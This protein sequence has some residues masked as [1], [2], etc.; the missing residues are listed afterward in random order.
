M[1]HN[2]TYRHGLSL[3]ITLFVVIHV[4]RTLTSFY[5][6]IMEHYVERGS[7][8]VEC[9]T[10]KRHSPCSTPSL[11]YRFEVCAFP[12]SPRHPSSLSCIDEYLAIDSGGNVNEYSSG[13]IAA[14]LAC[15]RRV[16][17]GMNRPAMGQSVKRFDRPN[18][19]YTALY[20][21]YLHF[22]YIKQ[23]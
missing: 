20:K 7:S 8:V 4:W 12:F 5:S 15:F 18:G 19:M 6:N 22:Y 21:T 23:V 11:C 17:V 1:L 2:L 14:W 13:V 10:R 16:S 9:W 3:H